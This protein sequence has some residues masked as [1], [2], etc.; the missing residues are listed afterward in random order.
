MRAR[1]LM[2]VAILFSIGIV[3]TGALW[4][5]RPAAS[6][7]PATAG[8]ADSPRCW[9][10]CRGLSRNTATQ[11]AA[12]ASCRAR[13]RVYISGATNSPDF[14]TFRPIQPASAGDTDAFVT[15]LSGTGDR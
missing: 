8:R 13:G 11:M 9:N 5:E 15:I 1:L 7:M 6:V 3:A 2:L 14:P 12:C 4:T 10:D